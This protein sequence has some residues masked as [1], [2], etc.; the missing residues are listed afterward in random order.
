MAV[1]AYYAPY[2]RA[3]ADG[4][5]DAKPRQRCIARKTIIR[6]RRE[7]ESHS[8][9]GAGAARQPCACP[10]LSV[11]ADPLHRAFSAGRQLRPD[12]AR[13]RAAHGGA[14][15]TVDRGREPRRRGRHDRSRHGGQGAC[16]RLH[17]RPRGSRGA[18]LEREPLSEHAVPTREGPG[19]GLDARHDPVLPHCSPLAAG[20]AEAG[21]RLREGKAGGARHRLWRQRLDHASGGRALQ[22][23]GGYQ[24]AAD[25]VQGQRPGVDRRARQSGAARHGGRALGDR[26]RAERQAASARGHLETPHLGGPGGAHL[27][28]SR[29]A[30]LRGDR[31]V[32]YRGAGGVVAALAEPE[33]RE[34]SLAAGAEPF[35]TTPQEFAAIIREETR[36]WAQVI[37]TAG[38]KLQ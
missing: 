15:G 19:A 25:P 16:R 2:T 13:D 8:R 35:T 4:G 34:R 32:R 18:L 36:K 29:R 5:V 6:R 21:D 31:L 24:A 27:R 22:H 3:F 20:D 23:D 9:A 12:R 38:I 14:D 30:G 28:G 11:Q 33:I 26:A 7:D 17:H 37:R 10:G 1:C